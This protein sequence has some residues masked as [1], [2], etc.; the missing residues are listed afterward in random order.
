MAAHQY[1]FP[2]SAARFGGDGLHDILRDFQIGYFPGFPRELPSHFFKCL[3]CN[4]K[5]LATG[6]FRFQRRW[7]HE[8]ESRPSRPLM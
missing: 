2:V 7:L 3:L 1:D 4:G 6:G 5:W 8:G